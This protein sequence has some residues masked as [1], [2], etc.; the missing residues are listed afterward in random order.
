MPGGD[1]YRQWYAARAAM[2]ARGVWKGK[3]PS[4]FVPEWEEGEPRP[5]E[6]A[7]GALFER[8]A[9]PSSDDDSPPIPPS[10]GST[11]PDSNPSTPDSL[12]PLESPETAEGTHEW[13]G[14]FSISIC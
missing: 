14:F 10:Q 2:K 1:K 9:N 8:V 7:L 12:P 3:Q 13:F 5:K 6:P 11:V 4:H